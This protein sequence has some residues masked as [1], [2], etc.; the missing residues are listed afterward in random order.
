MFLSEERKSLHF[1]VLYFQSAI[2]MQILFRKKNK[3]SLC[4]RFLD[5]INNN[6]AYINML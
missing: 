2:V 3:I 1:G 6:M 4:K 5:S